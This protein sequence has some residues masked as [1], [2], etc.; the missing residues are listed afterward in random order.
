M[1]DN[2][3][4]EQMKEKLAITRENG[5][6]EE[7]VKDLEVILM[8]YFRARE[9]I[10]TIPY[11]EELVDIFRKSGKKKKLAQKLDFMGRVYMIQPDFN[12]ALEYF[13]KA[14]DISRELEEKKEE[15]YC[16]LSLGMV[17]RRMGNLAES[18]ES[19]FKANE[20]MEQLQE[21]VDISKDMKFKGNYFQ[22]LDQLGV[23]YN[24]LK[25]PEQALQYMELSLQKAKEINYLSSIYTGL[26]NLGVFYSDKDL[27]KTLAYYQ[28]ALPYV[29]KAGNKDVLAIVLNNIGGVYED[30]ENYAQ[31]LEN[32]QK[33][34]AIAEEQKI[35][36]NLSIFLKHI[37]SVYFKQGKYEEALQYLNRSLAIA[38]QQCQKGEV[39]EIYKMLSDIYRALGKFG[40]TLKYYDQYTDLKDKRLNSEVIEKISHLQQKYEETHK[41]LVVTR[42]KNSLISEVLK[43][44][45]KMNF[46]GRTQSIKKVIDLAMMAAKHKDTNVLITGESGTGKEIIANMIHYASERS[47]NLFITVNSG[48]I[49]ETLM[50]SEFFGYKKGA[51]TGA[52]SDKAGYLQQADNGT[53]FLDEI[54]DM[55]FALQTK[56]LRVLECRRY[57]PLG[58]DCEITADF[59]LITATNKDIDKLISSDIFRIDLFYRIN[60]IEI[61]IPPLRERKSD[62]EPLVNYFITHFAQTLNK[63]APRLAVDVIEYLEKYSFPGNVRELRNMIERAMITLNSDTINKEDLALRLDIGKKSKAVDISSMT[64]DEMEYKMIMDA[65]KKTD[66]NITDAAKVLGIHYTTLSRKL[67]KLDMSKNYS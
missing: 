40:E 20:I 49:P 62:I 66:H 18:L 54:G 55:P 47:N 17:Q 2:S 35:E 51:F 28:E 7:L 16:L 45:M 64:L 3:Q 43:T 4:I 10:K 11:G 44:K 34:I 15:S 22:V 58:S 5:S 48:S 53:L 19:F 38:E 31:A 13:Q 9:I 26:I 56:L 33:A 42:Q 60:T 12:K 6:L 1:A 39:E 37:G 63:P 57:Q 46:I 25:Q 29:K 36:H 30:M 32:Y 23:I 27:E 8:A 65:L 61:Q 50:E 24:I 67:K 41:Q 52:A 21:K 59:R 14:L